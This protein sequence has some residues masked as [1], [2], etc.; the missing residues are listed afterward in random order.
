ML[1][2]IEVAVVNTSI[3]TYMLSEVDISNWKL[4]CWTLSTEIEGLTFIHLWFL[5]TSPYWYKLQH[6]EESKKLNSLPQLSVFANF[7]R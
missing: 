6:V 4:Y 2:V 3:L 5:M 1:K 7:Y